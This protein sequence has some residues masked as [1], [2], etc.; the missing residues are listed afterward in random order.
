MQRSLSSA[1][2][3]AVILPPDTEV[4]STGIA[5]RFIEGADLGEVVLQRWVIKGE[6]VELEPQPNVL[7]PGFY[8]GECHRRSR[9]LTGL[10]ASA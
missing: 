1:E 6:F 10:R 9:G 4:H 7:P 3:V 5:P 8:L 2:Q